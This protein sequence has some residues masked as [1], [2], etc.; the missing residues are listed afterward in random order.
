V[1][2]YPM[3]CCML[4]FVLS[5][6]LL[7]LSSTLFSILALCSIPVIFYAKRYRFSGSVWAYTYGIFYAFALFWITPYAIATA[8]RRGWLTRGAS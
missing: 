1:M 2:A 5:Y 3:L 4:L 8:R 7:F 6:P